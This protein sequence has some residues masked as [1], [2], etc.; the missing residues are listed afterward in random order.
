MTSPQFRWWTNRRHVTANR[1]LRCELH[2]YT[3]QDA[4]CDQQLGNGVGQSTASGRVHAP[5]EAIANNG[6]MLSLVYGE[7]LVSPEFGK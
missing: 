2:V 1:P 5:S 3:Q 4:E 6:P 7:I